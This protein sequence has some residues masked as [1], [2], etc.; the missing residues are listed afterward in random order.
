MKLIKRSSFL[1]QDVNKPK[2]KSL[3]TFLKG[4]IYTY[5]CAHTVYALLQQMEILQCE[6]VVVSIAKGLKYLRCVLPIQLQLNY[7]YY[8]SHIS[9]DEKYSVFCYYFWISTTTDNYCTKIGLMSNTI[10]VLKSYATFQHVN[11]INVCQYFLV[12]FF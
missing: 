11:N 3:C 2:V 10:N 4:S 7:N 5:N 8:K 1:S 6:F 12:V 9:Y